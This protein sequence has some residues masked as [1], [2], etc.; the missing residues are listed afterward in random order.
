[1]PTATPPPALLAIV[2]ITSNAFSGTVNATISS[3]GLVN[4]VTITPTLA[5]S[6]VLTVTG[7]TITTGSAANAFTVTPAAASKLVFT[8]SA[9]TGLVAGVSSGVMTVQR[10]D[11]FDNP[12]SADAALTINLTSNGSG[13][14]AFRNSADT[15]TLT[16]MTIAQGSHS[17][18]FR[19]RDEK[20]GSPTLTAAATGL[21]A[22][23][24]QQTVV[25]AALDHF[26][27]GAIGTQTAGTPFT[28][29]LTAQDA[30]NNTVTGFTGTASLS[31]TAGS[32]T[33]ST[34]GNFSSGTRTESV[35]VTGAGTGKTITVTASGKSGS[36][37]PFTVMPAAL[38]YLALDRQPGGA[39]S[40]V[41]FNPQPVIK[42]YDQYGNLRTNDSSSS[43]VASINTGT[44]SLNGTTTQIASGGIVTYTNLSI[45]QAG[46]FTLRFAV[47]ALGVN[48]NSF[49]VS[50][51]VL[52]NFLVEPSVSTATAGTA[53]DVTITPRDLNNNPTTF[54]G[55]VALTTTAGIITPA[56]VTWS[57]EGAKT[58]GVTVTGA[59]TG[60]VI[61][62]TASSSTGTSIPFTVNPGTATALS[63]T[64]PEGVEESVDIYNLRWSSAFTLTV[65]D[66]YGNVTTIPSETNYILS[67]TSA[68]G[69]FSPDASG[70]PIE[71]LV[72][73][74]AG[75]SYVNFYYSDSTLGTPTLTAS[76]ASGNNLG[77][78]LT[79]E[80]TV[81]RKSSQLAFISASQV[82]SAGQV[83]GIITVERQT[84]DNF[85]NTFDL[86]TTVNLTSSSG[87]YTFRNEENTAT[88]SSVVIPRG[89]SSANFRYM[90]TL[91]ATHTLTASAASIT[92]AQQPLTVT[93]A[94][95]NSMV[96]SGPT[97][98]TLNTSSGPYAVTVKDIYSNT[99]RV[100]QA[101]GLSLGA[102]GATFSA[103]AEG[104]NITQ[105][106]IGA[107]QSSATFFY[108][109]SVSGNRTFFVSQN[110]GAAFATVSYS[111][112]V[113]T[114]PTLTS[115][116]TLSGAT[117][118][119]AFSIPYT[120]LAAAANES[121]ADGNAIA[122]R[123]EAIS[124]GTLTKNG[125]VVTEGVTTLASGESWVWTPDLNANG[126]G[127]NAFTVVAYDG[128]ITSASPVQVKVDVAAVNDAP[129]L[130]ISAIP[131]VDE[132]ANL[133]LQNYVT[134]NDVDAASGNM[135]VTM[136]VSS[137]TINLTNVTGGVNPATAGSVRN[138]GT[139]TVVMTGTLTALQTTFAGSGARS[140]I[141]AI[142]TSTAR[143]RSWSPSTTAATPAAADTRPP[144]PAHPLPSTLSTTRLR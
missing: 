32:I 60:K 124:S 110:N 27:V 141:R 123:V 78:P 102:S 119:S 116:S 39:L 84:S 86:P 93:A 103:N 11:A 20:V 47:N 62:A 81:Y 18:S 15:A 143:T 87:S 114:P 125:V 73:L 74:Q 42:L 112:S 50:P 75:D 49:T 82:I 59:G 3:G 76:F 77:T 41:A 127:L 5:G 80:T 64:G 140:P 12:N 95:A 26:A 30:F 35:T 48:S 79:I 126:N 136:T 85:P 89:S 68:N 138:N 4:N 121:D 1:M 44:G 37:S 36:S 9:Y 96:I 55:S 19:Y 33:P 90:D 61:T 134:M 38:N 83:S 105:R 25:P 130:S 135:V 63:L 106:T 51:N 28:V 54:S 31:T 128:F 58:V 144:A 17:A 57:N 69:Q 53:F 88:I 107:G 108:K 40:G 142:S 6:V 94:A 29:T 7:G 100:S 97:Q 132:D 118:D 98:V 104:G 120:S 71:N 16:S 139:A 56:S 65:Q 129:T 131:A 14:Y 66:A 113:N 24:Q 137:G 22:T 91:A 8:S 111:V 45:N 109:S 46:S 43:V 10:R 72:T 2:S 101:V 21:T 13:T 99:A 70:T 23:T 67:S 52:Q 115:I 117:E 122:F 133:S 92:P 34:T